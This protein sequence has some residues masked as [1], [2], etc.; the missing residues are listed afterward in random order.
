MPV[1]PTQPLLT[2]RGRCQ[3]EVQPDLAEVTVTAIARGTDR[4]Q[5]TEQLAERH[6]AVGRV[7]AGLGDAVE[8]THSGRLSVHVQM[9]DRR[10]EQ[11]RRFVGRAATDVVVR[12]FDALSGLITG[13]GD[14]ELVQVDGPAWR[15]R[16]DND[17]YR[18]ARVE[19]AADAR[20]RARDYAGAFG[21]QV[22]GVVEVS[23]LGLM[24]PYQGHL[25]KARAAASF[26]PGGGHAP[27][28]DLTPEPQLVT[29]ELEVRFT[30]SQPDGDAL[31]GGPGGEPGIGEP[32]GER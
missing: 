15:L 11:V 20:R 29:G 31:A 28:F 12:D 7:V 17:V 21:A 32:G 24:D 30:M 4:A 6:A 9:A 25:R 22:T 8:R 10:K 26:G 13:V 1:N 16:R 14:V 3:L 27:R 18:R 19:A 2:V 5:V 23:D